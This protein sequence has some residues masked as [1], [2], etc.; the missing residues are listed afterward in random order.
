M[1]SCCGFATEHEPFTA[2]ATGQVSDLAR[3]S[4]LTQSC[5]RSQE[6]GDSWQEVGHVFGMTYSGGPSSRALN[7]PPELRPY[8]SI[9]TTHPTSTTIYRS[10]RTIL[11]FHNLK[12]LIQTQWLVATLLRPRST[13][14]AR[15]KTSSSLSTA[16]RLSRSGR[17]TPAFLSPRLSPVSRFW[18]LTSKSEPHS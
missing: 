4:H 2:R 16:P 18:L 17:R 5:M 6:N 7:T 15:P 14:R 8:P 11:S 9:I 10:Q 1:W 3:A 13:T 12:F